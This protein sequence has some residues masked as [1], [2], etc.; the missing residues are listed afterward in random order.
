MYSPICYDAQYYTI[1]PCNMFRGNSRTRKSFIYFT[2]RSN[3]N[4]PMAVK[5]LP[6]WS[7]NSHYVFLCVYTHKYIYIRTYINRVCIRID[8]SIIIPRRGRSCMTCLS[9]LYGRSSEEIVTITRFVY[10][11][12][13]VRVNLLLLWPLLIR[14]VM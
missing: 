3:Y 13:C 4:S 1:Y 10:F 12:I 11:I 7:W 14:I 2:T 6:T 8:T 5:K 9:S